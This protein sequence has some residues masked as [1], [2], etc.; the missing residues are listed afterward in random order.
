MKAT[1]RL[2]NSDIVFML[3]QTKLPFKEQFI[4]A[5]DFS[6][7][8]YAIKKLS[9]RGAPAIG[10]A[11]GFASYLALKESKSNNLERTFEKISSKLDLIE[12][13]RPTAVNLSWSIN[14]FRK[15]LELNKNKKIDFQSLL[16]LFRKEA[17]KIYEEEKKVSLKLSSLGSKLI[18]NNYKMITHCNTGSL[19]TT[20]PGTALGIIKF[21]N[22]IRSGLRVFVTETRPLLQGSR[23][24][25]WECQKNNINCT[26]ISD[27]MVSHIIKDEKINLIIVGA[28]RIASNG[29]TANKIGT[30]QLAIVAKFHKILFFVAAPVSTFDFSCRNGSS[31]EIEERDGKELL[32]INNKI[33]SKASNVRNPAFDIT[34][35]KLI[36]GIITEKGIIYNPNTNKIKR[37]KNRYS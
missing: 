8:I 20:G 14:R 19:A 4:R 7:I 13:A 34:P 28:D 22:K 24:T 26:L 1:I 6:K 25:V 31:I 32:S 12:S 18:K 3:D 37:F 23:L 29:D 15:I 36:T 16:S 21:A 30:C 2:S 35:R 27:S 17:L 33:I 9:I 10:V 11:G 5:K